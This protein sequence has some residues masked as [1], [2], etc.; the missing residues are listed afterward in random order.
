M[1]LRY[2][3]LKLDGFTRFA[4]TLQKDD[5][6][7]IHPFSIHHSL[8]FTLKKGDSLFLRV[9]PLFENPFNLQMGE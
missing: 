2:P 4:Y 1:S 8:P 5:S 9:N 3:S 6:P 7:F